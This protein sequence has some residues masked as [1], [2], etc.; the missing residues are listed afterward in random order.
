MVRNERRDTIVT[1]L[2]LLTFVY[3][4]C[5]NDRRAVTLSGG[6]L[7]HDSQSADAASGAAG[8]RRHFLWRATC[9]KL[10]LSDSV[11]PPSLTTRFIIGSHL[12]FV[13]I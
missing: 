4:V 7:W 10:S 3:R 9:R 1:S 11:G 8:N 5:V 6:R 2:Q 13:L 12:L